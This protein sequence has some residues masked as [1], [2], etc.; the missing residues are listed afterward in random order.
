MK[1]VSRFLWQITVNQQESGNK[2]ASKIK[3]DPRPVLCRVIYF[4]KKGMEKQND[5]GHVRTTVIR[6]FL[7]FSG[8]EAA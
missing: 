2:P 6:L 4:A 8:M 3:K 5:R 1:N 7:S